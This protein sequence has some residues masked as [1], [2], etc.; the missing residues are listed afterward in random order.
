MIASYLVK[1]FPATE[2][3][4]LIF[5]KIAVLNCKKLP[6]KYAVRFYTSGIFNITTL[7]SQ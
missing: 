2:A 3:G 5:Y 7:E 4:L 6:I 1:K